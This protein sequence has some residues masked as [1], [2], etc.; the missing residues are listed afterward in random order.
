VS[1]KT[2]I[3]SGRCVNGIAQ[4][5]GTVQWYKDGVEEGKCEGTLVDGKLTGKGKCIWANGNVYE[6][7]FVDD[8]LASKGKLTLANGDIYEGYFVNGKPHGKGKLTKANSD[9]YEG[10]YVDGKASK[11]KLTF[12][13]GTI[14]EGDF[15]DNKVVGKGKFTLPNGDVYESDFSN[16][17]VTGKVK[18]TSA[19]GVV[20]EV[21]WKDHVALEQVTN[22][23]NP[24]KTFTNSIGMEF[25]LIEPQGRC[26]DCYAKS[27]VQQC[28]RL[29]CRESFYLGKY[30]V[31]QGQWKK[32]MGKNPSHF[33][34][35]SVVGH[36]ASKIGAMLF[37]TY[38]VESVNI[39]NVESF[40]KKLNEMDKNKPWDKPYRLPTEQEWVFALQGG[41]DNEVAF[42]KDELGQYAWIPNNSGN[43][44]HPVGQKKPT[45]Y[46]LHDMLG[47]VWEWTCSEY[48]SNYDPVDRG[49]SSNTSSHRIF[50][51]GGRSFRSYRT[52]S[53]KDSYIGFRVIL[54]R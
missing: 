17:E 30:E 39:A 41:T 31:T 36:N 51:G 3:W 34:L 38:P 27:N 16:F 33:Q 14:Y 35:K 10:Y 50:R 32:V 1:N 19:N 4:G 24:P 47:N 53:Q 26:E 12:A 23:Q 52:S 18:L 29:N 11:G 15:A 21:N 22:S 28:A 45:A 13:N 20:Y 25:V 5:K 9:V 49:C 40:L 54:P 6:G 48:S 42:N 43:S 7:D 37:D 8:K 44:T 46:G 2:F